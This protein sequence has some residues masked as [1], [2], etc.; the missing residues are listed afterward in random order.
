MSNSF[1][2]LKAIF[3]NLGDSIHPIDIEKIEMLR[4]E[5]SSLG[6]VDFIRAFE[7]V[8]KENPEFKEIDSRYMMQQAKKLFK[9]YKKEL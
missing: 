9:L 4:D 2:K 8:K 7:E 6:L 5:D 3:N 1:N